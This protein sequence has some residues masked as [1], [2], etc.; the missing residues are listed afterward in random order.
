MEKMPYRPELAQHDVRFQP[1]VARSSEAAAITTDWRQGLP[2]LTGAGV[3]LRVCR[4]RR[5]C[6]R[7]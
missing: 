4:M 6:S 3:T 7:C 2:L 5:R 1:A